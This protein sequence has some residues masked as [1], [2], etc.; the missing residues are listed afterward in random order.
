MSL[1]FRDRV[2]LCPRSGWGPE[3]ASSA[4]P[5]QSL[6]AWIE[7]R[8]LS[9]NSFPALI[10]VPLNAGLMKPQRGFTLAAGKKKNEAARGARG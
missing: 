5:L 8:K 10:Q 2:I 9:P 1:H 3:E 6:I 7:G 4:Q